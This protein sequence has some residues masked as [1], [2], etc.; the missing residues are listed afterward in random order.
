MMKKKRI[1]SNSIFV[2]EWPDIMLMKDP[3]I[4]SF[5][6]ISLVNDLNYIS[7]ACII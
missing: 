2:N 7:R 6:T 4:M 3:D 1:G 5:S